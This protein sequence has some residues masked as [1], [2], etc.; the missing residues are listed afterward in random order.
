MWDV[1]TSSPESSTQMITEDT[2]ERESHINIKFSDLYQMLP[3][4]LTPNMA[5]DLSVAI[6]FVALLHLC[7]ENNLHLI[8]EDLEDIIIT[9]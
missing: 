9:Q 6:D 3:K 5:N 8:G 2:D 7:N 4:K 1:M